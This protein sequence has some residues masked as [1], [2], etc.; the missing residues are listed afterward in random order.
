MLML[1]SLGHCV[2]GTFIDF[3]L[4]QFVRMVLMTFQLGQDR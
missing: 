1:T 4:S 2:G 3:F